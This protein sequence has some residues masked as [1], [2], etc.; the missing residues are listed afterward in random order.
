MHRLFRLT[1]GAFVAISL[2]ACAHGT[3]GTM[4]QFA[5]AP[6]T[7]VQIGMPAPPSP[8]NVERACPGPVPIGVARCI[9]LVR[10]DVFEPAAFAGVVAGYGPADLQSAY[11]LPSSTA[12][13]GQTVAIVDAYDDGHAEADLGVY[14]THFGLPPC[15]SANGCFKK[16]NQGGRVGPYPV[17]NAGWSQEISLDLDMVSAV[18]PNCHILL[19][20][21]TSS[22]FSNLLAAVDMAASMGAKE[23]SNSYGGAEYSGESADS[24]HFNHPGVMITASSGDQGYGPQ[25]PAASQY[26]TAV[27]GTALSRSA[28]TRGWS[29]SAWTGA[30]SGCSAFIGKPAWQHDGLCPRRSIADVSAV[31]D[32][33]TGVAVYDQGWLVFGGTSVAAP[34]VASVYALAGNAA[35]SAYGRDSYLHLTSLF[36]VTIGSN[37]SCGSYLCTARSGF[38]GPTGNGTPHG[39]GAF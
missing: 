3:Q 13:R 23:I 17:G 8:T 30:G 28:N 29:E 37:G 1:A 18:C 4:P 2:A 33:G 20:E 25:F 16:V 39:V 10:T 34:I 21:A 36:D 24:A 7:V 31:A 14:R 9:A 26:V 22:S 15:T 11:K 6:S 19:V 27:G 12:G 35:T 32:P 38:D 5:A